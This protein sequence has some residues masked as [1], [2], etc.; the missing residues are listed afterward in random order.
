MAFVTGPRRLFVGAAGRSV[1]CPGRRRSR[2]AHRPSLSLARP[3]W[4]VVLMPALMSGEMELRHLRRSWNKPAA[5][6]VIE[7]R[8]NRLA[9][10]VVKPPLHNRI[11]IKKYLYN[12]RRFKLMP[13]AAQ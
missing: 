6:G 3:V 7:R 9:A 1:S 11:S 10:T 4:D 5:F 13:D 2:R 8:H 12:Q